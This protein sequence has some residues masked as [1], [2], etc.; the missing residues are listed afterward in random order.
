[1]RI[2]IS[3]ASF[4]NSLS[5]HIIPSSRSH[6]FQSFRIQLRWFYTIRTHSLAYSSNFNS[7]FVHHPT[8]MYFMWRSK[9]LSNDNIITEDGKRQII[10]RFFR[11]N[12]LYFTISFFLTII[13]IISAAKW[14]E[15][16]SSLYICWFCFCWFKKSIKWSEDPESPGQ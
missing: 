7:L 13:I 3:V 9:D 2:T 11:E 10:K 14:K 12:K 8:R 6:R 5:P 4:C 1:M 16:Y 15:Y